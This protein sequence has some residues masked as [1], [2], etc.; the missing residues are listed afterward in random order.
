VLL[1]S[2]VIMMVVIMITPSGNILGQWQQ[3]YLAHLLFEREEKLNKK[4][5][6]WADETFSISF[7]MAM[8]RW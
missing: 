1:L 4:V 3:F 5:D 7:L 2:T 6:C 8:G